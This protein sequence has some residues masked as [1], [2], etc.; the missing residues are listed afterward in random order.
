MLWEV[1]F[2]LSNQPSTNIKQQ[3][4]DWK[5]WGMSAIIFNFYVYLLFT[6]IEIK[7]SMLLLFIQN[8][9]ANGWW[10]NVV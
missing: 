6:G 8:D 2:G 1:Y 5:C 10:M 9:N 3:F 7:I 4:L